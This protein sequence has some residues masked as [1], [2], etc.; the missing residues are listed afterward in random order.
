MKYYSKAL[1][2]NSNNYYAN[3]GLGAVLVQRKAF[4]EAL[5]LLQKAISIKKPDLLLSILLFISYEALGEV[6]QAKETLK[7]ILT[8]YNDN[9]AAAYDGVAYKYYR[10]GMY[11]EAEHCIKEALKIRP[12]EVGIHYNL[13]RIYLAQGNIQKAR[14]EFQ[15]VL[16]NPSRKVDDERFRKYATDRIKDIEKMHEG[17]KM[18]PIKS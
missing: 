11:E 4:K 10:F 6:N 13:A 3:A 2:V 1:A 5:T 17:A 18:D 7:S 8:F 9:E 14:D 16:H 15:E 12:T